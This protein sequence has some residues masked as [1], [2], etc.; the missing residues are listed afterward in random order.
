M[1]S[2]HCGNVQDKEKTSAPGA[3]LY[4]VLGLSR[5]C[6]DA[7]LRV[8]YRRLAMI[9]HPDRCSASRSSARVE[10]AK[11]RFQEIQGAYSVLSDSNKRLLYDVGVYDSEDDEADLSGMGDFLGEM[12]D[13]MSQATPTETFE[14][15][16]Q[17]FVDMFQ[18]DLDAGFL[19]GLPTGHRAQAPSTSSPPSVS[20]SPPLRPT[21]AGRNKG[22][23]APSSSS[24]S[25]KGVERQARVGGPGTGSGPLRILLHG[26]L[27]DPTLVGLFHGLGA[28]VAPCIGLALQPR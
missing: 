7:E 1:A 28:A 9:W 27:V 10:E 18:D 25:F 16:Q 3:D 4:A 8:A 22:A 21:P 19:G 5:E 2:S 11:V 20:S 26:K 15:L 13:M 24:S 23:Q 17:V 14:E 6:T 12:A